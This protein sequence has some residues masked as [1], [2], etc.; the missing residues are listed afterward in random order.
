[1][2]AKKSE[3]VKHPSQSPQGEGDGGGATKL[4]NRCNLYGMYRLRILLY[5]GKVRTV[6]KTV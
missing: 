4:K 5:A 3:L 1:M 2:V 6:G